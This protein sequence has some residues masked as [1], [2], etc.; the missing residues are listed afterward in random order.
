MLGALLG[1]GVAG[2]GDMKTGAEV[3]GMVTPELID[4]DWCKS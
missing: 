3:Q 2:I 4:E 1:L